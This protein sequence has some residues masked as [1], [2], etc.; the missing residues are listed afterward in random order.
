MRGLILTQPEALLASKGELTEVRRVMKPQP[1]WEVDGMTFK[2]VDGL[3][4]LFVKGEICTTPYWKLI[5]GG[6]GDGLYGREQVRVVCIEKVNSTIRGHYL[7]DKKELVKS[8]A[9]R[10]RR[11]Y[12]KKKRHLG[13]FPAAQMPKWAAR[14]FWTITAVSVE[15]NDGNYEW[16]YKIERTEK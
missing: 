16:V 4:R 3:M 8:L 6:V 5:L 9:G 15:L 14:F 1:A 7:C 11:D 10:E 13:I 12:I 2:V